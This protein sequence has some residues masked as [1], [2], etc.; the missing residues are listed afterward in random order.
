[1]TAFTNAF[2]QSYPQI[3]DPVLTDTSTTQKLPIGTVIRAKDATY[4]EGSFIYLPGVASTIVGSVVTYD[5][6]N[7][8][9]AGATTLVSGTSYVG[10]VAVAMSANTATTSFGWYQIQGAAVVA[11]TGGSA[12]NLVW[13]TSTAGK[14]SGTSVSNQRVQGAMISQSAASNTC[15]V[16]LNY[17][18]IDAL[19]T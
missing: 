16:D 14:V 9:T 7:A 8:T 4:G 6:G 19:T 11:V 18:F 13:T 17:P 1:M 5:L 12:G 15:I 2:A 10:P 3:G